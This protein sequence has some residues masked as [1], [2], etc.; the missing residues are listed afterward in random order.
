MPLNKPVRRRRWLAWAIASIAFTAMAL[1]ALAPYVYA[2]YALRRH[3]ALVEPRPSQPVRGRW[4]DDYFVVEE[5]DPTT[6]AI[7]EPR[8]YQGNDS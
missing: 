3:G 8:Y 1:A 6:F 5:I 4:Y 2:E 7:G